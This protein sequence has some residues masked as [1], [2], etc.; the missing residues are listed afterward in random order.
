M[1]P[2]V[3]VASD[4]AW[5]YDSSHNLDMEKT[6]GGPIEDAATVQALTPFVLN[7]RDAWLPVLRLY[8]R[9][10]SSE[11]VYMTSDAGRTWARPGGFPGQGGGTFFS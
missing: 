9:D 2:P 8:A 11:Y 3:V 1:T 4:N 7:G 10:Q 5:L 6:P